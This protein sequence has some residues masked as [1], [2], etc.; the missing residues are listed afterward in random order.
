MEQVLQFLNPINFY[1]LL[2]DIYQQFLALFPPEIQWVV[3]LIVLI[4]LLASFYV[5]IRFH[6]LAILLLVIILPILIP[7][8]KGFFAQLYQFVLYLLNIVR[9]GSG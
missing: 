5:L 2:V 8:L 7:F 4:S 3:T 6:W 1:D 9:Q